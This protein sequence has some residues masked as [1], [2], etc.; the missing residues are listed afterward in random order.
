MFTAYFDDSGSPDDTMAVV[1]AGFVA[2]DDQWRQFER[3]WND[4][5][6]QFGISLFHMKEFAHST[7]EFSR[8]KGNKADREWF[9][10]Q[11]LSHINLRVRHSC[12][13][14][15][16]MDDFRDVNSR[17][18]FEAF[19]ITPYSLCGRTCLASVANWAQRWGIPEDQIRYV[20]EDGSK[21]K[22]TLEQR[23]LR[24]KS[25]TPVF[26]TKPPS[27]PLQ[28]ADLFA[29]EMLAGN[30][31]IF[32]RGVDSFDDLRYPIRQLR[33]LLRQPL[34]WG[35]YDRKDLEA[36]SQNAGVPRRNS[37]IAV[38]SG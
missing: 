22:G 27:V 32:E 19:D 10:R 5:L 20:F 21:G 28:A 7:G 26:K 25:I 11:L 17:Y 34:D 18:A 2:S 6:S 24:D 30:R 37:C 4:T 1:V 29:Y 36:F 31:A 13:H 38:V 15:V 33:P 35:T 12:G 23:I 14:A 8:F 3:N 16:L 9:L